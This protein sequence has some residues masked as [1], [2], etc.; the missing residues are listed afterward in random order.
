MQKDS[1]GSQGLPGCFS[2][3]GYR[4]LLF[5]SAHLGETPHFLARLRPEGHGAGG[6]GGQY[7]MVM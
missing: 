4:V 2:L 5:F 7:A 3:Q 1:T 6:G